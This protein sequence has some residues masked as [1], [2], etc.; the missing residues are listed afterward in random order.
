MSGVT[1]PLGVAL[2]IGAAFGMVAGLW[3]IGNP[4]T[5][6]RAARLVDRLLLG[7]FLFVTAVGA[8]V[9]YGLHALGVPMHFAPKPL[10]VFGVIAGGVLFG[11]GAAISG[12]FPGTALIALGEGRRDALAAIPGGLLG[13]AAWTA[14]F[15]TPV[16]QWLTTTANYGGL[17][18]GGYLNAQ[19]TGRMLAVAVGYA[20]L[21][22]MLLKYLPRFRGGQRCCLRELGGATPSAFER[23][24]MRD[25]IAYLY[26]GTKERPGR[27][28]PWFERVYRAQVAHPAFFTRTIAVVATGVAAL[29]VLSIFLRQP[30]GQSTTYSWVVGELFMPH[31]AYSHQVIRSIGWE[32]LS[33]LGVLIGAFLTARFLSGRFTAFRPVVPPSWRHR[34]GPGRTTRAAAV[35]VG[36]FLTL[37]GARM[38]GGC[39]S[40]HTLSGGIQLSVSAWLFTASMLAA[41][42]ITAR[43]VYRNA[44]WSITPE[45]EDHAVGSTTGS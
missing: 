1:A 22:F 4:E 30:F 24:M 31:F 13:A 34:F 27:R 25:T 26:E 42:V 16:G 5:V 37:F 8:V 11:T 7:C 19:A 14:L 33:D 40:G 18:A 32:P 29:V 28:R 2:P 20:A 39:T 3:G 36:S 45:T 15:G 43:L 10:Y 23:R 38:A 17:V 41:M 44:D 12:Y 6:I 21:A 9:L 35:F